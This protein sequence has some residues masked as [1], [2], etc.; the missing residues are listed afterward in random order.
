MIYF[1]SN[2]LVVI[3]ANILSICFIYL[4]SKLK[5]NTIKKVKYNKKNIKTYMWKKKYNKN[6]KS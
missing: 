3:S 1:Y 2:L 5:K 4:I 6:T